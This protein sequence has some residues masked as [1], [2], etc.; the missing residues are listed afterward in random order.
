MQ[1]VQAAHPDKQGQWPL[2]L[3]GDSNDYLWAEYP[4]PQE[5]FRLHSRTGRGN[6]RS[7]RGEIL[8]RAAQS[9]AC[10]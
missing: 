4:D 8:P 7:V 1:T 10:R 5:R 3:P 9:V 6:D 2:L